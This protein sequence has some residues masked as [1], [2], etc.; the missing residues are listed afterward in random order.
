METELKE[1]INKIVVIDTKSS[2]IYIGTLENI[3]K[4]FLTLKDVDVHDHNDSNTTKE[5]YT[6]EALKYKI[7]I[8]RYSVKVKLEEIISI[9]KLEEVVKY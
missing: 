8:N 5:I 4:Y 3:G 7:K 6:M 9:S 1:Y 2:Y